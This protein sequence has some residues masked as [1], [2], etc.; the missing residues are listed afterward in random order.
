[1]K[2]YIVARVAADDYPSTVGWKPLVPPL[3]LG[4][5]GAASAYEKVPN[6]DATLARMAIHKQK[7]FPTVGSPEGTS[8]PFLGVEALEPAPPPPE[9]CPM[10]QQRLSQSFRKL[11]HEMLQ[12]PGLFELNIFALY[13]PH[14]L[15][16][17][18]LFGAFALLYA[19]ATTRCKSSR[20]FS[21]ARPP[22]I[23]ELARWLTS[24]FSTD[25]LAD[26]LRL[27][28]HLQGTSRVRHWRWASGCTRLCSSRMT[29]DTWNLRARASGT[30]P[31]VGSSRRGRRV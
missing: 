8:L 28:P 17:S 27:F 2:H 16:C 25:Y 22:T 4:W 7:G 10:E 30:T 12:E 13:W 15:R 19:Y 14:M 29:R 31:L 1:M 5:P 11:R 21:A 6:V 18:V 9:I 3:H 26:L 23:A 24:A 20:A